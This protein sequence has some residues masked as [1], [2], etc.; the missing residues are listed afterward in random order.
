MKQHRTARSVQELMLEPTGTRFQH[1][2]FAPGS[3]QDSPACGMLRV[4]AA[5]QMAA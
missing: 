3:A 1:R 2:D 5:H 4:V